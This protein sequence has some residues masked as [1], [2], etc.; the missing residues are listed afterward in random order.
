MSG[1]T[2][3]KRRKRVKWHEW[4]RELGPEGFNTHHRM[5]RVTYEKLFTKLQD[6]LQTDSS[7][8]RYGSGAVT[9]GTQRLKH[10]QG[11]STHSIKKHKRMGD[12]CMLCVKTTTNDITNH[13]TLFVL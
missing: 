5:W 9:P 4:V 10:L 13:Y 12:S 7:K 11:D 2:Y 1:L 6:S 8:V 3:H